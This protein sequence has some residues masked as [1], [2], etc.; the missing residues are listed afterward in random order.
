MNTMASQ[1]SVNSRWTLLQAVK[2]VLVFRVIPGAVTAHI[3]VCVIAIVHLQHLMDV[4]A[5]TDTAWPPL[6]HF[7]CELTIYAC[8]CVSVC[9]HTWKVPQPPPTQAIAQFH[10]RQ[11]LGVPSE[12]CQT[13]GH[14]RLWIQPH[15]IGSTKGE[16][17]AGRQESGGRARTWT[18]VVSIIS[19]NSISTAAIASTF[20]ASNLLRPFS[21]TESLTLLSRREGA[22]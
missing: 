13:T 9:T 21:N 4:P 8:S 19:C 10:T 3:T 12:H 16:L 22:V 20:T 18:A 1:G 6:L 15:L 11:R 7:Q 14:R 2:Q 5:C 17:H